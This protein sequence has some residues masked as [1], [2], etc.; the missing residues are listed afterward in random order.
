MAVSGERR[1]KKEDG[2]PA[3]RVCFEAPQWNELTEWISKLTEAKKQS[4]ALCY[5]NFYSVVLTNGQCVFGRE[6]DGERVLVCINAADQPFF[7][8]FDMGKGDATDLITGEQVTLNGG[9]ELPPYSA[10]FLR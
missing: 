1:Q 8:G 3:L 9:L 6:C 4:K 2:D 7:A 10:Y 5:G